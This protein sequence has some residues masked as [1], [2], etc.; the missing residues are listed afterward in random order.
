MEVI[1]FFHEKELQNLRK[2]LSPINSNMLLPEVKTRILKA[3]IPN[4]YI[5][6]LDF[7]D[8]YIA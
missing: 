7:S 4:F 5:L 8:K 3:S 6:Y 1:G 2:I